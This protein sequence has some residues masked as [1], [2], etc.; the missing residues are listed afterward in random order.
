MN[1]RQV[2]VSIDDFFSLIEYAVGKDL[3]VQMR[4][5][6]S[7]FGNIQRIKE[8]VIIHIVTQKTAIKSELSRLRELE[9]IQDRCRQEEM[10]TFN[11]ILKSNARTTPKA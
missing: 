5:H 6:Y 8:I 10:F 9:K 1:E 3:C 2:T 4:K 7:K 11:E